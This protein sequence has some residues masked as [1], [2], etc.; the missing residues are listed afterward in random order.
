MKADA[1]KL[2]TNCRGC[3][4]YAKQPN[5]PAAELITIPITWPFAVWNLDMVGKLKRSSSGSCE[6][7]LVAIDKFTKWIE[8]RPVRK[9]DGATSLK[10]V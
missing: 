10:F 1:K 8:A 4:F 5:A 9:A 6:Y 2:V 3:Q 7:L